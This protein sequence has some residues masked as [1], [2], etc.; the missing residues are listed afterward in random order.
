MWFDGEAVSDQ[1][2]V[3][4]LLAARLDA[5]DLSYMIT[6]SIAAGLYGQPRM[7]R[8]IDV[9]AMLYPPH[10]VRLGAIL[11]HEFTADAESI[12]EAIVAR[13]MFSV[14][15]REALQKV[16]FIVREPDRAPR[17]RNGIAKFLAL[18]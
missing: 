17:I 6:G 15:H 4:K 14:M 3:L 5:A 2:E 13:R 10:A 16:D 8:D 18:C 1:L 7:T 9:V 11:G 12:R